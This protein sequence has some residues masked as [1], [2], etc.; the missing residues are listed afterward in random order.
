MAKPVRID[1]IDE[2]FPTQKAAL[3]HFE[4]IKDRYPAGA[5][6]Q[7]VDKTQVKAVYEQYCAVTNWAVPP[8]ISAYSVD[9]KAEEIS[10]GQFRTQKCFWYHLPDGTK[11]D[12]SIIKAI[13]KISRAQNG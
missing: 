3:D 4:R 6:L 9:N 12:F 1:S 10:P 2:P 5:Q 8:S 7:G 13:Q 11:E